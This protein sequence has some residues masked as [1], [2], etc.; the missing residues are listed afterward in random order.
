[1]SVTSIS[2]KNKYMLWSIS[3]GRCQYRGCNQILHT[4]ILTK[5]NFNKSYIAHIVADS[6]GGPRGCSTRSVQLADDISNLMLLCDTHHRLIDRDD[7]TGNPESLLLEMK[8]E[9]ENRIA[10]AC[11]I[12]PDKQS[13][14][15]TLNM[16]IGVHTPN[17]QYS[18]VSQFLAPD[19]YPAEAKNIDLGIINSLN[20]DSD[21]NFWSDEL[22][23]LNQKFERFLFPLLNSGEIKHISLFPFG[24]MPI[25][26]KL[27]TMLN[28]IYSV[29]VRQKR[30]NPDTW[31]F[32]ADID[33]VYN[34]ELAAEVKTKIALKIE[35]SDTITDDRITSVLG[36]DTSIYSIKIDHP[37]NDFVKSRKQITDF[38]EKMKEAFREIKR[39]HGQEAI[40]NIFP[41]MPVSLAVQLGRV[42]MPKADLSM[43]IFDQNRAVRGFVKAIDIV[44]QTA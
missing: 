17:V 16:N 38:G 6:P 44:H 36:G 13:H 33:T 11:A 40:L 28:D 30:R 41:A 35:L 43:T 37:D 26:M 12:A 34:L 3:G 10:N 25:L 1:M 39:V 2:D 21:P 7:V 8:A 18:I 19:Y 42:W 15:V 14:I 27:G 32:E 4:D 20:K 9:H 23:N 29:D 22:R 31:N 5:R 24:P